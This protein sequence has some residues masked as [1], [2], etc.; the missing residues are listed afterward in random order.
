MVTEWWVGQPSAATRAHCALISDSNTARTR[1]STR[2]KRA[3]AWEEQVAG[4]PAAIIRGAESR[5]RT[6]EFRLVLQQLHPVLLQLRRITVYRR[7]P[8]ATV[9]YWAGPW[10]PIG[11]RRTSGMPGLRIE[12]QSSAAPS[13]TPSCSV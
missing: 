5:D 10:P 13:S 1:C 6:A 8:W 12:G 11:S 3:A 2:R 9:T 4:Q 7:L